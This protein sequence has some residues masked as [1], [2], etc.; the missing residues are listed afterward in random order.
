[1]TAAYC[2]VGGGI[3]G[4]VAAY[5]LR[6]TATRYQL[7]SQTF[8]VRPSTAAR[9]RSVRRGADGDVRATLAFPAYGADDLIPPPPPVEVRVPRARV[10]GGR[11]VL[12]AGAVRDRF[13][14]PAAAA[15]LPLG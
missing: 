12:G 3:S 7:I 1:M 9:V 13:G 11:V 15:S 4:L 10:G 6:V 8:T 2:V 5:R 14:N